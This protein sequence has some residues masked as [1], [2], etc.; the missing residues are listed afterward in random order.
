MDVPEA[1]EKL[2]ALR[3][4]FARRKRKPVILGISAVTG[5]GIDPLLDAVAKALRG[6]VPGKERL[7]KKKVGKP[8]KTSAR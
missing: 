4:S 2:A 8:R 7:G 3:K 6:E 5:E 1:A